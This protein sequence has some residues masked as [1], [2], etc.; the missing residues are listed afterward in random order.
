MRPILIVAVLLLSLAMT[1]CA[2]EQPETSET[3]AEAGGGGMMEGSADGEAGMLTGAVAA[4]KN[5]SLTVGSGASTASGVRVETLL[6][7]AE[8]WVVVRSGSA[9]GVVLGKTWVPKGP[10]NDVVV[11]L[12]AADTADVRVAL[13][14]DQGV[15][16]TFEFDPDR[17]ELSLDKPIVVDGTALEERIALTGY[18]AAVLGNSVLLLVE[19]QAVVNDTITVRYLLLPAPGWVSVNAVDKGLPGKQVGLAFRPAGESQQ[20]VV[21]VEGATPGEYAV[22]VLADQG[23]S[24]VFEFSA[25]DPLASA[26]QPF[27]SAGV[28]VSK[29]ITLR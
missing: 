2:A 15:R 16:R 24:G 13:H 22:T 14:V 9:P 5:A 6:A 3:A 7:P 11:K 1:G 12:T 29:R 26:D 25:S 4:S 21:P 10:N 23:K 28:I 17:A 20:V 27:K 18:G 8:G 19:D